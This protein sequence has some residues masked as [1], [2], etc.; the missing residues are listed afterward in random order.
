VVAVVE[1]VVV[2]PLVEVEVPVDLFID[3]V[4]P[5]LME[6]H[7]LSVLELVE[8]VNLLEEILL[9]FHSPL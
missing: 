2:T 3:M 6:H 8:L 4:F 7:I 9:D 5:Y 1:Q